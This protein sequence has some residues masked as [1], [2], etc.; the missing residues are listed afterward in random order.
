M[1]SKLVA[2]LKTSSGQILL[3]GQDLSEKSDTRRVVMHSNKIGFTFQANNLV[4]YLSAVEKVELVLRLKNKLDDAGRLRARELLARLELGER[5][6]NLPGQM[7]G[8]Q[9]HARGY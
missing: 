6:N 8:G 5:Q 1:L 4:P 3:G 2:L 9:Q 7:S